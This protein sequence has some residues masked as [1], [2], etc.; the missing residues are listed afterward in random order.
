MKVFIKIL[1]SQESGYS[2]NTPGQRGKYILVPKPC[3]DFFPPLSE[4]VF[5]DF[6]VIPI[7]CPSGDIV[8]ANYVWH[9]AGHNEEFM[10][11]HG[12]TRAHDE[13]RIYRNNDLD[14]LLGLDRYVILCI[15][16]KDSAAAYEAIAFKVG[17]KAYDDVK[18]MV[19]GNNALYCSGTRAEDLYGQL[20]TPHA[21]PAEEQPVKNILALVEDTKQKGMLDYRPADNDPL[22]PFADAFK[23]QT[24]FSQTVATVYGECCALRGTKL[25]KDNVI[26]LE[27]AHIHWRAEGGPYLPSNGI[28]LSADLHKAFDRGCWTLSDELNVTLHQDARGGVLE[29]FEGFKIV[30]K[31]DPNIYSPFKTYVEWHRQ[32][33][34]GRFKKDVGSVLL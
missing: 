24:A 19:G 3:W 27:A 30:P 25:M 11:R 31:H 12:Y 13:R 2:G 26:G 32:H 18:R 33:I 22:A 14:T 8:G 28:L 10:R 9:N 15:A 7:R 34:F 20:F 23:T 16:A 21:Q 1:Q 6:K 5:N 4:S 29:Q 17:D